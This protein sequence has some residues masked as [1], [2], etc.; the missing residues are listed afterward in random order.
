MTEKLKSCPFCNSDDTYI[1]VNPIT[2]KCY[3]IWCTN[4]DV[5]GPGNHFKKFAIKAW[6]T[7]VKE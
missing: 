2:K 7:R 5:R 6:N 3:Y 1:Q 4:C